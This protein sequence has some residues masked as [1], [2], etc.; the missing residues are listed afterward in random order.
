MK[1]LVLLVVAI[2]LLVGCGGGSPG[3]DEDV[4]EIRERLFIAQVNDIRINADSYVG[5]TLRYE[6][7]FQS[8]VWPG[9]GQTYYQVIRYTSDDCCGTDGIIGFEVYLGDIAPLLD[10][11][12]A[13]VTG[14]LEWFEAGG[15]P[16]LRLVV[17]SLTELAERGAEIVSM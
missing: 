1:K 13:E 14:V 2:L 16:F 6:G 5:R 12:W 9:T 10:N 11:S 8:F 15:E 7:L 3:S 17:V 4:V